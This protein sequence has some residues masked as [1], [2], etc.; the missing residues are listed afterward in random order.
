MYSHNDKFDK[1]DG[2]NSRQ[3]PLEFRPKDVNERR[4]VWREE[5]QLEAHDIYLAP[6]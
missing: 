6:E 1:I 4:L 2:S 5:W 3:D